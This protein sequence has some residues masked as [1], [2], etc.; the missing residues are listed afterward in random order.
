MPEKSEVE[1]Q[2]NQ[3]H[4]QRNKNIWIV[5][6]LLMSISIYIQREKVFTTSIGIWAP[7][8][9]VL[10]LGLRMLLFRVYYRRWRN[11]EIWAIWFSNFGQILLSLG[12]MMHFWSI[13]LT[14]GANSYNASNT[15]IIIAGIITGASISSVAHKPT[16][17]YLAGTLCLALFITYLM[18]PGADDSVALYSLIFYFFNTYNL[19]LGQKQLCRSV[20]NEIQ[21]RLEKEKITRII[22]TVPG[23]VSVYD[24]NLVCTL[25]NQAVLAVFPDIMGKYIGELDHEADWEKYLTGFLMGGKQHSVEEAHY[26]KAG[27]EIWMLRNAQRSFDGGVVFVSMEITELVEARNRLREQEAVSHYTAKLASLGEMAAGI[28]HEINNPLTIIQGSASVIAKLVEQEPMDVDTIKLLTS[29]LNQTS[30]RISKT[31]R[32]LKTLSRSGEN[33]PFEELDLEKMLNTCL[34]LLRQRFVREEVQL[35]LPN[36][37]Q[38]IIF[39][40]RE[41]QISQ[42]L[43]NLISNAV[44]A[45]K[46]LPNAWI[47]I[48]YAYRPDSIDIFVTD[49][50]PGVPEKIRDR[51]M[52]PFFTTKEVNQGTGLGLSI[53]KSILHA[54]K[55]ELTL[56]NS[57]HTTFRIH[58]PLNL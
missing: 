53:S 50:G 17:H 52:E 47:E 22:D 20:A 14:Y 39:K 4:L 41:I 42:V 19:N 44:D 27:K 58:L 29:K 25:A 34:D 36:F 1:I 2:L 32:S 7:L 15:V 31:I 48:S 43:M 55:G 18:T 13:Y 21:A 46:N 11:K 40:G 26:T 8:V 10:A 3:I 57:P 49:S 38:P 6:V 37:E 24:K 33:D 51:I 12:W 16:Y 28:A 45:A 5:H 9:I 56:L 54:H 35:K 23:Y 30:E